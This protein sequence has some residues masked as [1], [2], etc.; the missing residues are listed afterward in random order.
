MAETPESH[1]D[2]NEANVDVAATEDNQ[3]MLDAVASGDFDGALIISQWKNINNYD[4]GLCDRF[5]STVDYQKAIR[6]V[7]QAHGPRP[8]SAVARPVANLVDRFENPLVVEE[9]T[10][11]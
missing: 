6:H 7:R 5:V 2:F 10:N 1:D 4:C 3:A 8:V 11:G 9:K